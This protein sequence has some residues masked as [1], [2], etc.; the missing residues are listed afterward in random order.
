MRHVRYGAVAGTR[1]LAEW[2]SAE[3]HTRVLDD[4]QSSR[5][6]FV[7][8]ALDHVK[9]PRCHGIR[10]LIAGS[11]EDYAGEHLARRCQE[12]TEVEIECDHYPSLIPGVREDVGIEHPVV[13]GLPRMNDVVVAV[14][15][16][17]YRQ[18]GDAHV[19]E[20]LQ[21]PRPVPVAGSVSSLA[22]N[23]AYLRACSTSAASRSG[24]CVRISGVVIPFATKLTTSDTVMRI[25]RI[26]ARPPMTPGVNVSRSNIVGPSEHISL[27]A[28]WGGLSN[29][30]RGER[31][32]RRVPKNLRIRQ[33]PLKHFGFEMRVV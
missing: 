6:E 3:S 5:H 33:S 9:N 22:R 24:Y 12:I 13:A 27:P 16:G 17:C 25:P 20:K 29:V 21:A 7:G 18:V 10:T 32:R 2:K 28:A 8:E 1:K 26:Q 30:R 19:G 14:T 23:E 15:K 31:A 4:D 11:D